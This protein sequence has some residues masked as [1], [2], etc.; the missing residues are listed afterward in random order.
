MVRSSSR[1]GVVA[2]AA[3]A[4]LAGFVDGF[5][6][7]YLGGYFVSFMS[8]NTTRV[9]V[10]LGA[11]DLA[12][13]GW[14]ALLIASFVAGVM[15]GTVLA[16]PAWRWSSTAVLGL[17]ALALA[18]A[19]LLAASGVT[20]AAAAALAVGMGAVNTT[21][22]GGGEVSF[23]ITYTTG[24]LVKIGQG[25]V[26]ALR[27]GSRTTWVRHLVLWLSI[28]GGA[29]IGAFSQRTIGE[30]ALWIAVAWVAVVAG[31]LQLRPAQR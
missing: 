8:G 17:V 15:A 12:A 3:L 28:L 23:G 18:A 5:G 26:T 27:G 4:L 2:V 21:F 25:L 10:G 13:A 30:A 29:G 31:T 16:R 6:Y 7:V 22:S 11:D 19:A 20:P 9:G 1:R 24:A 14:G